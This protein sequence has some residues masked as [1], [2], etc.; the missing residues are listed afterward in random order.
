MQCEQQPAAVVAAKATVHTS[1]FRAYQL[2]SAVAQ[3]SGAAACCVR[4]SPS[5][6]TCG[7]ACVVAACFAALIEM[8][9]SG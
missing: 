4:L 6:Q 9:L 7:L 8:A 3:P 1:A 5:S 2:P